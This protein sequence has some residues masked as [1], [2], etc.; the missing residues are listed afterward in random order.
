MN[1]LVKLPLFLG[2]CGAACAG[3][4][5]GI[6]ALTAPIIENARIEKANAAYIKMYQEFNVVGSD[7]QTEEVEDDALLKAGCSVRAIVENSQVRGIAYTCS[8]NGYG[9]TINFQVA[10]AN[11]KYLGYTDLGNSET[12]GYG[13]TLISGM[14]DL[15]H[16]VDGNQ[17]LS[18][19]AAYTSAISGR[20]ITGKALANSIEVC[21]ADYMNWYTK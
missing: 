2:I 16:G 21:R 20:S 8:V 19:Y 11:G 14:N 18:S 10:F 7:V 13:K 5:A 9:G 3:V 15:I 17:A 6:N 4:L 1:K 12:N